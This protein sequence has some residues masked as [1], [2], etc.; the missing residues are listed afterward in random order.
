ME[1]L[2]VPN[3]LWHR[4]AGQTAERLWREK[5]GDKRKLLIGDY[6]HRQVKLRFG[7]ALPAKAAR[8]R[9]QWF[10][11]VNTKLCF[12]K[13]HNRSRW[14]SYQPSLRE[15][16][17][18]WQLNAFLRLHGNTTTRQLI[19]HLQAYKQHFPQHAKKIQRDRLYLSH[20]WKQTKTSPS[21]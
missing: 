8:K 1:L 9:Q 12:L 3:N 13:R 10:D 4:Y 5:Q 6:A 21:K 16:Q 11:D 20:R 15:T 18:R 7:Q 2:Q 14:R 17:R 19:Q